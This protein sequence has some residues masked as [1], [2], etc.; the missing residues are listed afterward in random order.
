MKL[1]VGF[2]LCILVGLGFTYCNV[3]LG[4]MFG[5]LITVL[6]LKRMG[7]SVP[8][9]PG[10]MTVIQLSLGTS[11]GL[12]FRDFSFGAQEHI[13]FL[14]LLLLLCLSLQ[15][16]ACY[17]WCIHRLRWSRDEALLG[18]VPG[19]MAAVLAL[20]SHIKTP[21]QKIII[22]HSLRLITLTLFAGYISGGAHTPTDFPPV[23]FTAT[24]MLWLLGIVLAGYVLG[25]CLG[26]IHFPAP[27]MI[28][29]LLCAA[30]LHP[31]SSQTVLFPDIFNQFS[32]ALMGILLGHHFIAFTLTAFMRH[33]WSSM[34]LIT[35]GLGVTVV[36]TLATSHL[37]DY[38]FY[39]L[40]LS[41]VPGSVE[42]MSFAALALKADAGF[43]MASHIIRMLIIQALP[44]IVIYRKREV[45]QGNGAKMRKPTKPL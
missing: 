27:F 35:I 3:P 45:M 40:M 17:L 36:M 9:L 4:M 11:I 24:N 19:A 44:A 32:M 38:P 10:S 31:L 25:K 37:L 39:L 7:F 42:S 26:R 22:S 28:T 5:S 15:F 1:L 43:V 8:V 34:Q 13:A 21:P 16:T 18:A 33:L 23:L 30:L 20:A 14:L 29:S 41:W 6:L 12:L 2:V